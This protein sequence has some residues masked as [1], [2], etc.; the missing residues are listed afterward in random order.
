VS[1]LQVRRAQELTRGFD[2]LELNP[3]ARLRELRLAMAGRETPTMD[4]TELHDLVHEVYLQV[5]EELTI[6]PTSWTR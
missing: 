4:W 2:S 5:I 3:S 1:Q 6:R